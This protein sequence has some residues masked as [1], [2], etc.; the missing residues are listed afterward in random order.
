VL[1][2]CHRLAL[3]EGQ[4]ENKKWR[5]EK[6]KVPKKSLYMWFLVAIAI[7][8]LVLPVMADTSLSA[9]D[10][11]YDPLGDNNSWSFEVD[12]HG[13]TTD[14][15]YRTSVQHLEGS[16]SWYTSGGGDYYMWRYVDSNHALNAIKGKKV[17]FSFSFY[18]KTVASDGSENQARP[19]IY[20]EYTTTG[21]GCPYVSAWNGWKYIL[22]NNLMPNSESSARDVVDYYL[23]QQPLVPD[24][25][26]SCRLL[27]SEFEGEHD[28]FE[29]VQFLAVDRPSNVSVAVSPYGEILTYTNP[30][31]PVSAITNEHEN[32]KQLLSS[33]D[34]N[35]YEG[36]DGSYITLNFGDGLDVSQG[37]KLVLTADIAYKLS[38]HVQI[39]DEEGDWNDVATV[40]P[41]VKW[42][43]EIIDMSEYLP[44]TKGNLKVRLYFTANHKIDFV[45]LDT[46]PQATMNIQQAE[47]V[48]AKHSKNG[49]PTVC[50]GTPESDVKS[51]LLY[52]DGTYAELLPSEQIE[53]TFA[54]QEKEVTNGL[55]RNF[56]FVCRGHYR[57]LPLGTLVD[58]TVYGDWVEPVECK[59]YTPYVVVDLPSTTTSVKV[60]IHGK[61]DFKAYV[62]AAVFTI[63]DVKQMTSDYGSLSVI[64]DIYSWRIEQGATYGGVVLAGIS[65]AADAASGYY[66][67]ETKL[68]AELLP[69]PGT[70]EKQH[71][72]LNIPYAAQTNNKGHKIDPTAEEHYNVWVHNVVAYGVK[73]GVGTAVGM[74]IPVALPVVVKVFASTAA[75]STVLY[76]LSLFESS[77]QQ[78]EASYQAGTT[79]VWEQWTYPSYYSEVQ[80]CPFVSLASGDAD[81][82][83]QFDR[84]SADA[85]KIKITGY[86]NWAESIY[87]PGHYG[88]DHWYLR[89]IKWESQYLYLTVNA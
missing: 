79:T 58:P 82:T 12:E 60:I 39:Q 6:L 37:A 33:V 9:P 59:W 76:T 53:L 10:F 86:V 77:P 27:L 15:G 83:W 67:Y 78:R 25:E 32:V 24:G 3:S 55:A 11:F 36:Y 45:G 88:V 35:Y 18:P 89:P 21:G 29:Q 74:V 4:K 16:A 31:P 28:F 63:A 20:Y 51:K 61:P 23:L 30:H 1:E 34:G 50:S 43:T 70:S 56:V 87:V 62:D 73:V 38:I 71:G 52:S 85:F 47:L 80:P 44:D 65:L 49:D 5:N 19:E 26:G 54:L 48:S 40:I 46:S 72:S 13:W 17:K 22:D 7:A 69:T 64:L 57:S 41:R 14:G 42:A 84:D 68:Q 66:I 75:T 2:A 8:V 81:L